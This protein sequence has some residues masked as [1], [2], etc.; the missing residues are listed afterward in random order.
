MKAAFDAAAREVYRRTR[1]FLRPTIYDAGRSGVGLR[2]A[3]NIPFPAGS[4]EAHLRETLAWLARAQD[5]TGN[6]GISALFDLRNGWDVSYPETSGYTIATFLAAE[7]HLRDTSFLE[8]ARRIGDWEIAIQAPSGGVYSRPGKSALRVFNT[9]Q[10]ILGWVALFER[11]GDEQYLEAAR[12]AGDYL[13][14]GQEDDGTWRQDT[15]CGARTYHARVDW[16]LLRLA[17][18]TGSEAYAGAAARNLAWVMK[19]QRDNGWFDNCGFDDQ[20]P[21]THL[22]DYTF[23]GVLE[24]AV[25]MPSAF[26]R[27]AADCILSG[28]L[29]ICDIVD[30]HR[31]A[32]I[33]GLI[34][35]SF[36]RNWRSRDRYSCLTGNAQLAYTLL[37][38]Y[39]LTGNIRYRDTASKLIDGLK[40]TQSLH[41]REDGIRGAV[42]GCFPVY[43]GYL[44]GQYPNW[45]AKFFADALLARIGG[46]TPVIVAA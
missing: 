4:D 20:D 21:I 26:E 29:A 19:Q 22:I 30:A 28:A 45:A 38:L 13:L 11:T 42:A 7:A 9:G 15:H 33:E 39:G 31:I 8:R 17:K 24:S 43:G 18:A 44:A 12:R 35:G 40:Q 32:G 46:E 10:V 5:A 1:A 3:L 36:D 23:I 27:A 2:Y 41:G 25:L 37:R 16:A 6:G 34:P 14:R